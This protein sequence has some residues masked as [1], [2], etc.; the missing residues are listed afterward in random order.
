MTGYVTIVLH[1]ESIASVASV[2]ISDRYLKVTVGC[3]FCCLDLVVYVV[4]S[5]SMAIVISYTSCKHIW[6][7]YIKKFVIVEM[8]YESFGQILKYLISLS[9]PGYMLLHLSFL[10]S[11][12]TVSC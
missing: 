3:K 11:K 10:M 5:W 8:L 6:H 9:V 1:T 7:S 4:T 12:N 2:G